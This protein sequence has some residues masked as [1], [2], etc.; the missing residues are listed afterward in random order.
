VSSELAP[1][2]STDDGTEFDLLFTG[3]LLFDG[4]GGAPIRADVGV[5]NGK[6]AA[7]APELSGRATQV[8][9]GRG[10]W[11]MPGLI[12]IHTHFDLELEVDPLLPEAVRHGT[13]SVVIGNCSLGL[14]FGLLGDRALPRE[15]PVVAC[16]ARVETLP[17]AVI[18]RCIAGADWTESG[19]YLAHLASLNLGV[20][21]APLLPHSMLRIK[22][23]GLERSLGAEPSTSELDQ[24]TALVHIAM[25]Q[26][27]IGLSTDRLPLHFLASRRFADRCIPSQ[28][29][30]YH[31]LNRLLGVVRRHEGVWQTTPD[32][33]RTLLTL[34]QLLQSSG[35]LHGK[36]LRV[37]VAAAM[38]MRSNRFGYL[39]LLAL[40]WAL[41]TRL[42]AS[43]FNFQALSA[44]FKV[45]AEGAYTPLFE[46]E[47]VLREINAIDIDDV[48]NRALLYADPSFRARFETLWSRAPKS[49]LRRLVDTLLFRTSN[50]D[51]RLEHMILTGPLDAWQ[52]LSLA[53]L[54]DRLLR[55]QAGD[56]VVAEDEEA[57]FAGLP[58]APGEGAFL[59]GLLSH[60]DT[61]LRWYTVAAN[62]H[63]GR[64]QKLLMHE[65]HLPGFN[66][67]G[68]HL[69]NIAFYD[70][71]L[72]TLQIA[73]ARSIPETARAVRRLTH[74]PAEF[75]GLDVGV[76][77]PGRAADLVLI[78][79][80]ALGAYD[81]D[82]VTERRFR[83][84]LDSEQLVN[85]SDGV[86]ACVIVGGQIRWDGRHCLAPVGSAGGRLLTNKRRAARAP[87]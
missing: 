48:E 11:L 5:R 13:T 24:M 44:P 31:E 35:R 40:S 29:A 53:D 19:A 4:Y 66:D 69:R 72:R 50:F 87:A 79:P 7:V 21:V 54:Y 38:D 6:I 80:V 68:A 46:E 17:V 9:D 49:V 15:S 85:R 3:A 64:L 25:E 83:P 81:A 56:A 75:F 58:P 39:Q 65:Q 10:K 84:E 2:A 62:A 32:P 63:A 82:S 67:S 76:V 22:T 41:N 74:D 30:D 61:E 45:H 28:Y 16:F 57:V 52:G 18:A 60:F 86:V 47:P 14:A 55:W 59:L 71:N 8:I 73:A 1:G 77:E 36:A 23:M 42:L 26:G 78:D 37:T 20:N 43:H 27:Y 34:R 12:D 70:G 51:G 33:N